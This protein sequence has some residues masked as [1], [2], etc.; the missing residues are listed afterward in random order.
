MLIEV[1]TYSQR[2]N[3]AADVVIAILNQNPLYFDIH[4][5]PVNIQPKAKPNSR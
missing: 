3:R 2:R 1:S 5:F 4:H